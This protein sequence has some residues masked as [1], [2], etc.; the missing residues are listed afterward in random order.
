MF[1]APLG[2]A[3]DT[4]GGGYCGTIAVMTEG[5]Y[6]PVLLVADWQTA[7]P[8]GLT[9]GEKV[10][11]CVIFVA[12]HATAGGVGARGGAILCVGGVLSAVLLPPVRADAGHTDVGVCVAV[13]AADPPRRRQHTC[14]FVF[15]LCSFLGAKV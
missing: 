12:T 10:R 9:K 1:I 6:V 3:I 2:L 14:D 13:L 4:S 11:V 8:K 7:E 5:V 15:S